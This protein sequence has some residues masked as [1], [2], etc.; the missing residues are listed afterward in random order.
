MP[1]LT[2]QDP[3][4]GV[5]TDQF[6]NGYTL[7]LT[8][9]ATCTGFGN[10]SCAITSNSTENKIL[11]PVRSARL[12]TKGKKSITYGRV[13]VVA[14]MPKGDWLWPAIWYVYLSSSASI[15]HADT[16]IG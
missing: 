13:E 8:A 15:V 16:N 1:T 11:N 3:D 2:L 12:T 7:N 5:T 10:G 14:K 9:D 6:M 4:S